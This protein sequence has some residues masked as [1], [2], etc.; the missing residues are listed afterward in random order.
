MHS[1]SISNHVVIPMSFIWYRHLP[2]AERV[3]QA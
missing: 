2:A 3:E 1:L